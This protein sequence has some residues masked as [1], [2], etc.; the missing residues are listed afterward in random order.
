MF[1]DYTTYKIRTSQSKTLLELSFCVTWIKKLP[2]MYPVHTGFRLE[3]LKEKDCFED[4]G[5]DGIT[6]LKCI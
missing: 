1:I 3:N 4:L 2:G 6:T 5:I